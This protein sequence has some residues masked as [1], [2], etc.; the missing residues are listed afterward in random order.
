[1]LGHLRL[2]AFLATTHGERARRFYCETLG[3][4]IVHDHAFAFVRDANGTRLCVQ[5]E[6]HGGMDQDERRSGRRPAAPGSPGSRTRTAAC[7]P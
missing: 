5:F 1:M 2:M 4:A 6:R 3:L 7:C